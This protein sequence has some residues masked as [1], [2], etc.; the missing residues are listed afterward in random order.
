[1]FGKGVTERNQTGIIVV[2]SRVNW[3]VISTFVIDKW[4]YRFLD[5]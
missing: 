1:M 2:C 5:N 3:T 4:V